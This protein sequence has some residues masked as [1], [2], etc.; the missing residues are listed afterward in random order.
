MI[1]RSC[2]TVHFLKFGLGCGTTVNDFIALNQLS[3]GELIGT[4]NNPVLMKVSCRSLIT[5]GSIIQK[6]KWMTL[7]TSSKAKFLLFLYYTL[8]GLHRIKSSHFSSAYPPAKRYWTLLGGAQDLTT[9]M[10]CSSSTICDGDSNDVEISTR[11]GWLCWSVHP[12]FQTDSHDA[13]C[14]CQSICSSGRFGARDC[15]IR[16]N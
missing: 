15:C 13:Y 2:L 9:E 14:T 7:K 11:I 8:A 5:S 16:L 12:G 3:I 10:T 4:Q 1:T 6:V